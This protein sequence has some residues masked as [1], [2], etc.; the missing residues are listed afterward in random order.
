MVRTNDLSDSQA[1][2]P[3]P[4][5]ARIGQGGLANAGITRRPEKHMTATIT[6]S[7]AAVNAGKPYVMTE[8]YN[9]ESATRGVYK[10]RPAYCRNVLQLVAAYREALLA[11]ES[12]MSL[13]LGGCDPYRYYLHGGW[14]DGSYGQLRDRSDALYRRLADGQ[15]SADLLA[16]ACG[17]AEAH[18][19]YM[20]QAMR[21]AGMAIPDYLIQNPALPP[22]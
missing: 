22:A 15:D 5:Y 19:I 17:F 13:L 16:D 2:S 4:A 21:D 7:P 18:G 9:W 1:P 10:N 6:H 8:Y 12:V 20:R 3:D 14:G 11:A